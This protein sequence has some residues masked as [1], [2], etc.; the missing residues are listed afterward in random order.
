MTTRFPSNTKG[1]IQW[2]AND[3]RSSG[4]FISPGSD[5]WIQEFGA[6]GVT[7]MRVQYLYQIPNGRGDYHTDLQ[8]DVLPSSVFPSNT[9]NYYFDAP[10]HRFGPLV[11]PDGGRLVVKFTFSRPWPSA[12]TNVFQVVAYC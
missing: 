9:T 11:A 4:G 5:G 2:V 12:D 1:Y 6:S 3:C 7:Q 10:A 8:S